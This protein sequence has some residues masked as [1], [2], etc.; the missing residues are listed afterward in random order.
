MYLIENDTNQLYKMKF[1]PNKKFA[2]EHLDAFI[3]E[4]ILDYTRLRNYDYGV[5][6]RNNVSLL[7]PFISHRILFEFDIIK[8][9]LKKYPY[10]K[11]DKFVQEVFW[12][13]YWKGW[14]ELR[15]SVWSD[16][17]KSLDNF[18]QNQDYLNAIKSSFSNSFK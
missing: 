4:Q 2:I 12:R 16:F 8:K 5:E 11:V 1:L 3:E 13:V 15:P 10:S 14:L 6:N 17:I 9:V 7:S 18:Q